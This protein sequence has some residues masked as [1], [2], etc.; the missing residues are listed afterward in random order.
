MNSI[1][2]VVKGFWTFSLFIRVVKMWFGVGALE[3]STKV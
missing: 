2:G 3:I 1:V